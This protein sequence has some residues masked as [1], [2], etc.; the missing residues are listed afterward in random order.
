MIEMWTN[1][2][3]IDPITVADF[4]SKSGNPVSFAEL[5]DMTHKTFSFNFE[6][7]LEI[8]KQRF[9]RRRIAHTITKLAV[10]IKDDSVDPDILASE[11]IMELSKVIE[12]EHK[13]VARF[14]EVANLLIATIKA[15]HVPESIPTGFSNLDF[16][17][18]G[19][20]RRGNLIV[21]GARPSMGKTSLVC[22]MAVN[23]AS[24]GKKVLMFPMEMNSN[25]IA[26]R[27]IASESDIEPAV[28]RNLNYQTDWEAIKGRISKLQGKD[29]WIDDEHALTSQKAIAA[30]KNLAA[31]LGS[32]DCVIIDYLQRFA[33]IPNDNRNAYLGKVTKTFAS[34]ARQLDCPVILV[35][36]LSRK[37]E[38][39]SEK[40]PTMADLRDSGEIEADAD[41]IML[42]Y[43]K[44]QYDKEADPNEAQVIIAKQRDGPTDIVPLHWDSTRLRFSCYDT[45]YWED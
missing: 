22:Q 16:A 39:R 32:L 14:D 25:A 11:A 23:I 36:Q 35:S 34:L 28:L 37:V 29:L 17:L 8:L 44:H 19:G 38:D 7:D 13:T 45:R 27:I 15:G 5:I 2:H 41:V 33:D 1:D 42:L 43:R 4:M 30:A 6:A 3:D 40:I 24:R 9:H 20:F 31:R 12:P 10:S 21:I 18:A 26:T